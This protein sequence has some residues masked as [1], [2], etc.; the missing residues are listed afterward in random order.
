MRLLKF[1]HKFVV[2]L[3]LLNIIL[4]S[5]V[6]LVVVICEIIYRSQGSQE[7]E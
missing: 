7:L 5:M 6:F 4:I 3:Y 2:P 1:A